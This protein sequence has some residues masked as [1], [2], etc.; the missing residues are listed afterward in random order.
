MLVIDAKE[1]VRENSRRHGYILG[2]LGIE[3][4][5]VVVNKMDL[6]GYSQE[7]F[8]RIE[9]EY[10]EFLAGIGTVTP[11]QFIPIAALHGAGRAGRR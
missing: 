9:R 3:Q 10:R 7:V 5:I 4:V 2:M 6:P 11:L 8:D 1:G